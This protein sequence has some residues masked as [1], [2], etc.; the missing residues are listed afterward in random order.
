MRTSPE[1]CFGY[2]IC[3]TEQG[4]AW[5]AFDDAGEVQA[6]GV[7]PNKAVAAALVIRAL[8]RAAAPDQ[9]VRTAA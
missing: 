2:R 4:W 5:I 8:A 7:A 3:A 9:P 1:T 6:H